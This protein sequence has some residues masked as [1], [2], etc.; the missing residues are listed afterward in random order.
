MGFE[1][2]NIGRK[3]IT[4]RGIWLEGVH[5]VVIS[6]VVGNHLRLPF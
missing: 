6:L 2:V 1:V 4:T 3:L 5:D